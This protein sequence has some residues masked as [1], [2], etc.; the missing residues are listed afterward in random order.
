MTSTNINMCEY[1]I[2]EKNTYMCM[3]THSQIFLKNG[4]IGNK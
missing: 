3:Y 1:S 4:K 2:F